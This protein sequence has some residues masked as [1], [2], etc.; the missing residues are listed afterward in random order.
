MKIVAFLKDLI[1]QGWKQKEIAIKCGYTPTHINRIIKTNHAEIVT[2]ERIAKAFG[3]PVS[4]FLEEEPTSGRILNQEEEILLDL[5]GQ[6]RELLRDA[7]KH[8]EKEKL[9][10][11]IKEKG[12]AA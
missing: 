4:M 10:R 8:V 5:C 1:S 2:I 6:D 9:F 3:K 7:I 12:R 11:E